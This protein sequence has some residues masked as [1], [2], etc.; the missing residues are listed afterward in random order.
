MLSLSN[1]NK[2]QKYN[3][4]Q[5]LKVLFKIVLYKDPKIVSQIRQ[6]YYPL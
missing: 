1:N 4:V 3:L 5:N 6:L 2:Q